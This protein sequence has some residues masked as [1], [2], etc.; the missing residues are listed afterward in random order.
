MYTKETLQNK[1]KAELVNAIIELQEKHTEELKELQDAIE[2]PTGLI[3]SKDELINALKAD[4]ESALAKNEEL[5]KNN[6]DLKAICNEQEAVINELSIANS[7]APVA[8][9]NS[10]KPII[11]VEGKKY[12][13][14]LKKFIFAG[15]EYIPETITEEVAKKLIEKKSSALRAI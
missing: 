15:T 12:E 6:D 7:K 13:V 9:V 1:N 4:V 8:T 5:I 10:G 11:S 2:D 3:A 14:R